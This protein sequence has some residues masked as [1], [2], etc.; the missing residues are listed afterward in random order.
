M[1]TQGVKPK[2]ALKAARDK[3]NPAMEEYNTRVGG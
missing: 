2:A 1:F 3:A